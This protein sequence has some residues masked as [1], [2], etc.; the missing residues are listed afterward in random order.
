[1]G[2]DARG[3]EWMGAA[4]GHQGVGGQWAGLPGIGAGGRFGP[5]QLAL[6]AYAC[7]AGFRQAALTDG[8]L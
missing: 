7:D 5:Q 1:M 2:W 4:L 6:R 3:L 8:G